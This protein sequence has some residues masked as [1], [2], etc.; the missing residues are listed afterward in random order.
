MSKY[1]CLC[2]AHYKTKTLSELHL[3]MNEGHVIFE[4]TKWQRFWEYFWGC[5]WLRIFAFCR[6]LFDLFDYNASF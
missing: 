1:H 5:D 6:R 3:H 4:H 2:G